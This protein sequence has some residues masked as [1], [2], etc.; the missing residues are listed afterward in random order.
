M[1]LVDEAISK[2]G[3]GFLG[4]NPAISNANVVV[5][6]VAHLEVPGAHA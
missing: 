5:R 3:E 2:W 6:N 4:Q 1:H